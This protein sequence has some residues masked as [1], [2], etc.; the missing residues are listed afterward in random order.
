M[1]YFEEE[2]GTAPGTRVRVET[3]LAVPRLLGPV[4]RLVM[5]R[6]I[7]SDLARAE[8]ILQSA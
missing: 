2:A 4:A 7:R 5:T 6:L 3:E 8:R 1:L